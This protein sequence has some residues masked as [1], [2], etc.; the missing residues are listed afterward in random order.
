LT[1]RADKLDYFDA[2][3]RAVYSGQVRGEVEGMTL[4]ADRVDVYFAASPAGQVDRIVADGHITAV[5]PK[6]RVSGEHAEYLAGPGTIVMTGG[7]PSIYDL[8]QGFTSGQRLTFFIHDDS[9]LVDGGH[10]SPTIS[11]RRAVR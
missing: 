8:E 3:R 4:S 1:V 2:E 7:H 10:Q 11:K 9:L 5:D 6:R